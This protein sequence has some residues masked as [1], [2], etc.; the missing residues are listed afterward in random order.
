MAGLTLMHASGG[1]KPNN[2]LGRRIADWPDMPRTSRVHSMLQRIAPAIGLFLLSPL[3]LE[4]LLGNVAIDALPAGLF[5]APMYGG[6]AILVREAARRAGR[7]WP[8]MILLALAYAVVEEGLVIQTLFNPSCFGFELLRGAYIPTLAIGAWWTLFVLTLH[9][10]WSIS[11][12]IA[13]RRA[14]STWSATWSSLW[15]RSRCLPQPPAPRPGR[16]R[17]CYPSPRTAPASTKANRGTRRR[18][19]LSEHIEKVRPLLRFN[20]EG[21]A[22]RPKTVVD[23]RREVAAGQ[24]LRAPCSLHSWAA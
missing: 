5:F 16:E 3:V 7:G 18:H 20:W 24:S 6:G 13:I 9:T 23:L 15:Q 1:V 14:R 21:V 8:T 10:V 2:L 19:W 12:P 11:V 4:F 17:R 22:Q